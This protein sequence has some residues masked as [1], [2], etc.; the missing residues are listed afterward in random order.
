[1]LQTGVPERLTIKLKENLHT[2][3]G[4]YSHLTLSLSSQHQLIHLHTYVQ[5]QGYVYDVCVGGHYT[6]KK[7]DTAKE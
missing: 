7:T 1:M 3:H 6:I 2:A 5:G 4:T